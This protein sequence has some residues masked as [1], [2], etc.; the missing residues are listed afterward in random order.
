MYNIANKIRSS[1]TAEEPH[2][3]LHQLKYGH[4]LSELLKTESWRCGTA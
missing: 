3:V 4:F 1:A 2:N